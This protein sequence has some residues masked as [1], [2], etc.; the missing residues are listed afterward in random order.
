MVENNSFPVKWSCLAKDRLI[1]VYDYIE[2]KSSANI[3][4]KVTLGLVDVA[5]MAGQNPYLFSECRELPSRTKQYRNIVSQNYRI[6]YKIKSDFILIL[7]IFHSKRNPKVL[8]K[9]RRVK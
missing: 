3:A 1:E 7:D 6:I 9:L 4:E 2:S 5:E 8:K